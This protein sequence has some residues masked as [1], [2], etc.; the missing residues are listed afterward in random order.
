MAMTGNMLLARALVRVGAQKS[1]ILDASKVCGTESIQMI[2]VR[3]EQAAAVTAHAYARV[4]ARH[5]VVSI[6]RWTL[7]IGHGN[8]DLG[9]V[10]DA[11]TVLR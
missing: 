3:Q 4:F 7:V 1:P 10:G 9:I 11:K 6:L 5:G 8:L 2:D